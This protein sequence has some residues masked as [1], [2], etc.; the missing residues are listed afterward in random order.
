MHERATALT[1]RGSETAHTT[2]C[3]EGFYEDGSAS[4]KRQAFITPRFV[5]K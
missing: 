2:V 5:S 3:W 1:E 4:K